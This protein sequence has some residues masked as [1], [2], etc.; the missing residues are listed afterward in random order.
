LRTADLKKMEVFHHKGIRHV[1]NISK[2][3][4]ATD[5]LKNIDL[6]R[7]LDGIATIQETIEERR[8]DWLGNVARQ[9]DNNLPRRLLTARTAH[10]RNNCGQ[11]HTLR[12]S[13]TAAINRM[14][15]YNDIEAAPSN[16]CPS[17]TW[18]P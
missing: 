13:N 4:Q 15:L 6:R 14:L 9:P 7:K 11:K 3:H 12:D 2:W 16:E 1:L 8:L 17:K 10:P 18:I 5:R